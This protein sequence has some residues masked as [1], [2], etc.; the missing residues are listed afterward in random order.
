VSLTP[1]HLDAIA[2]ARGD[3]PALLATIARVATEALD[4]ALFTCM[5]FDAERG[6]VE[7]IYST[8][9]AAYPVGGRKQK[10]DTAW[11]EHVLT[12]Q[13]MFVGEGEDAIRGAFDDHATI[14]GLGLRS[15]VN[16]PVIA[17]GRCVGTVNFLMRSATIPPTDVAAA[18]ILG[19]LAGP[20]FGV[21]E[22]S[23]G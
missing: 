22:A 17:H 7:R 21:A 10:R 6:E 19:Q 4:C 13:Q 3:P 5:R 15:I 12:R 23:S 8:N 16:V 9:S 2:E 1:A 14:L 18:L 11:A 20:A